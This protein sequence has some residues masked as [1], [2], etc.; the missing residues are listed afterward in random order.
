[1]A[2]QPC[3]APL[4]CQAQGILPARP[5][6]AA[7]R[8]HAA[9]GPA[10]WQP[11]GPAAGCRRAG[12]LPAAPPAAAGHRGA[13]GG[14]W[15]CLLGFSADVEAGPGMHAARCAL[16]AHITAEMIPRLLRT[17]LAAAGGA[18]PDSHQGIAALAGFRARLGGAAERLC[19]EPVARRQRRQRKLLVWHE[20]A[21]G[22]AAGC[23]A[24]APAACRGCSTAASDTRG[25]SHGQLTAQ[26]GAQRAPLPTPP[27]SSCVLK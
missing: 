11:A 7:H 16:I 26:R 5:A 27:I 19:C 14:E 13:L 21:V 6:L 2:V 8:P 3:S 4:P 24:A 20:L 22:R 12:A 15:G 1:M 10:V 18:P 25:G 9:A 23:A 17:G